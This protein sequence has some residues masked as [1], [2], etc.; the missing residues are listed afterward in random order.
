MPSDPD[1]NVPKIDD[2]DSI[3]GDVYFADKS[4]ASLCPEASSSDSK[5][6]RQQSSTAIQDKDVKKD[7]LSDLSPAP[8]YNPPIESPPEPLAKSDRAE[9]KW[10]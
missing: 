2:P 5:T 6:P 7:E 1:K 9:V 4:N 8:S 3:P 10:L